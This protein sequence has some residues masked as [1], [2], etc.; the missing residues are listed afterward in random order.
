[1]LSY[2][3]VLEPVYLSLIALLAAISGIVMGAA[4]G[5]NAV[6]TFRPAP[7]TFDSMRPTFFLFPVFN[8]P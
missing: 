3:L 4:S 2:T 5:K 6:P 8:R 1:M 7:T